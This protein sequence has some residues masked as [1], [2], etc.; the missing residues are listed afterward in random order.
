MYR[1]QDPG[2]LE[3]SES[4]LSPYLRDNLYLPAFVFGCMIHLGLFLGMLKI[5]VKVNVGVGVG[6]K[7]VPKEG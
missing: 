4:S 5:N 2:L 6:F 7:T 3:G 1:H